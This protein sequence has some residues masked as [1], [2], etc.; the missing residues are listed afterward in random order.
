MKN[1]NL[2]YFSWNEFYV[3]EYNS[4]KYNQYGGVTIRINRLLEG[5]YFVCNGCFNIIIKKENGITYSKIE[6]ADDSEYKILDDTIFYDLSVSNLKNL[7]KECFVFESDYLYYKYNKDYEEMLNKMKLL[8]NSVANFE[9]CNKNIV[10]D[11]IRNLKD[12][13]NDLENRIINLEN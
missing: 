5:T 2:V 9:A 3:P 11:S 1:N 12:S 10:I 13:L 6:G 4:R 8:R 7:P